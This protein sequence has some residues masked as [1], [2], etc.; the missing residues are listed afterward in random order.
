MKLKKGLFAL[1]A[2]GA[3]AAPAYADIGVSIGIGIPLAPPAVIYEP[4]P[5]P[6]AYGYVWVPGYWG[7]HG[8][9]Y[10]WIRGRQV[11]ARPGYVWAPDRWEHRGDR[12]HRVQGG[13][14][15]DKQWKHRRGRGRD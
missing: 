12:W 15:R 3:M 5:P 11:V 7:W 6:P 14:Q 1:L 8:D 2:T 4:V 10:I 13:W 9:R